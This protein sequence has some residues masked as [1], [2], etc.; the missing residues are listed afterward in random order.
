MDVDMGLDDQ[1]EV[2]NDDV[3]ENEGCIQILIMDEIFMNIYFGK[4]QIN[5]L[6]KNFS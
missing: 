4:C 3:E 5:I 2:Y 6:F 1:N